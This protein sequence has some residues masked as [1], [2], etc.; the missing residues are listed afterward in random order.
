MGISNQG[1]IIHNTNK[2]NGNHSDL[3]GESPK[4]GWVE[5]AHPFFGIFFLQTE[6]INGNYEQGI[7]KILER[8]H[9]ARVVNSPSS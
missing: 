9:Q 1:Q 5:D 8:E 6:R 7:L 3:F 4:K 2:I